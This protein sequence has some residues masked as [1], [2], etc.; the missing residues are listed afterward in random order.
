M[1][2]RIVMVIA[3]DQFRDEELHVPRDLF[4]KEGWH[5]DTVSTQAGAATGMLGATENIQLTLEDIV[6]ENYDAAIVVGGMG[7]MAYLWPNTQLHDL[8]KT[9][10]RTGKI[11]GA[12]CISGAVLAN[13]G[14]LR[15][16]KATVWETPETLEALQLGG[17]QYTGEACTT[18]GNIVT[19]N[20][21]EAAEVFGK[22]VAERV[23]TLTTV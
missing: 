13:A 7:S 9:V 12:I 10:A 2:K 5:V 21:P 1:S 20:G 4:R 18:D 14:L 15:G 6:A 8:L 17:A 22:A 23:K 19:A 11:V 3:P 16:K